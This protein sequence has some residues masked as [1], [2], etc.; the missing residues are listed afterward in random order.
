MTQAHNATLT[1][2]N[3]EITVMR[4]ELSAALFRGSRSRAVASI[5]IADITDISATEP[6]ALNC[7]FV[8]LGGTG[9]KIEFP[10]GEAG[11]KA[12]QAF[13]SDVRDAQ[14]GDAPADGAVAGLSFLA[15][16][17]ATTE[18]TPRIDAISYRDG[19]A[20]E[21]YSFTPAEFAHYVKENRELADGTTPIIAHNGFYYLAVLQRALTAAEL[22]ADVKGLALSYGCTLALA[23]DASARAVIDVEDHELESVARALAIEDTTDPA[24]TT[25]EVLVALALREHHRGSVAELFSATNFA[26]GQLHDGTHQPVLR[27]DLS[28]KPGGGTEQAGSDESTAATNSANTMNA[29]NAANTAKQTASSSKKS[30]GAS[31]KSGNSGKPNNSSQPTLWQAVATPDTVPEANADADSSHPLFGEHVTLTGEFEPYDKG[32]LWSDIAERGANIGKNV[33]KKTTV[34]VV[35]E[36]AK[37]TSKEKRAEELNEKGQG[38]EI[39]PASK[40]FAVLGLDE[41]PPF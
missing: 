26:L 14:K 7:G 23:R 35:G 25:G 12:L 11:T 34:L 13:I 4:S 5:S 41:Q 32:R 39:W 17:V 9:N 36:W 31:K 27:T 21:Q 20:A 10:P 29:T 38:I 40:L 28:H 19:Q 24:R 1:V 33:T 3:E 8:E 15:I 22:A 16:H 6:T 37:K 30:R 18:D 2:S